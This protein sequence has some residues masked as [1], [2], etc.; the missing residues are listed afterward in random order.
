[1]ASL[2][3]LR[4]SRSIEEIHNVTRTKILNSPALEGSKGLLGL[5]G[6]KKEECFNKSV[7]LTR[8]SLGITIKRNKICEVVSNCDNNKKNV[9]VIEEASGETDNIKDK[10]VGDK[11]KIGMS[12]V[13]DY[14][15]S[16]ES[17]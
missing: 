3:S 11:S 13:G 8:N 4:P 1:M 5:K 17:D 7:Q 15:S 12:L 10:E 14:S 16:G 9:G 2:L 6:F